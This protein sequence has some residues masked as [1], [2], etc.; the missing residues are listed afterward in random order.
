MFYLIFTRCTNSKNLL[1]HSKKIIS[2]CTL[3]DEKRSSYRYIGVA[4]YI[5]SLRIVDCVTAQ[6]WVDSRLQ[7]KF[8][9]TASCFALNDRCVV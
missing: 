1:D 5:G 6:R 8:H 2:E 3:S 4:R 9:Y 7:I